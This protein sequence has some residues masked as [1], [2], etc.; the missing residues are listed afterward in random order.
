MLISFF[1]FFQVGQCQ[2]KAADRAATCSKYFRLPSGDEA[3]LMD[4]VAN[5][6]PISVAIDASQPSFFLFKKGEFFKIAFM[7]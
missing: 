6:G 7:P 1:G 2:Y 5:V 4:A 3:S